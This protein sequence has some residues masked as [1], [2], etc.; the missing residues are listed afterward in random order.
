M[1]TRAAHQLPTNRGLLKMLIFSPL[2]LSIYPLVV[3]SR[4]STEI[5][6]VA[7]RHDGKHTMHYCLI[8]FLLSGITLGI[9][10]IV[11]LHRISGRIGCELKRRGIA[12]KFS[13][14][15]FWLWSVLGSLIFVGPF[16]FIHKFLKAMNL[17][18][19][20]YNQRG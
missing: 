15:D 6:T 9:A 8:Y 2:T 20:D 17:L 4:I 16:V 12:Y 14:A 5:N 1:E 3:Y 18:N 10:P 11:W 7:S 19:A 13:S